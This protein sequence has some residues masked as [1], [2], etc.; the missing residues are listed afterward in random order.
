MPSSDIEKT[1]A[2]ILSSRGEKPVEAMLRDAI[3]AERLRCMRIAR[4]HA[5]SFIKNT[6]EEADAIPAGLLIADEIDGS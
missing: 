4:E 5:E 2:A 1:V 6:D 3:T